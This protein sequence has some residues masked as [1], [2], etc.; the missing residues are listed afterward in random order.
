[1]YYESSKIDGKADF[2]KKIQT[3]VEYSPI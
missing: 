3:K 1:M 2:I